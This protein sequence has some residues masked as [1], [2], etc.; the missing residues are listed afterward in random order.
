MKTAFVLYPDMTALDIVGPYEIISR[1]PDT[2]VHFL[3]ASLEPG[4]L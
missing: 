3:A 1:W 4:A 2:D